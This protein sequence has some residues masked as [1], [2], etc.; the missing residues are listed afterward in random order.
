MSKN[1]NKTSKKEKSSVLVENTSLYRNSLIITQDVN[2]IVSKMP[3]DYK[4]VCG[5]HLISLNQN[6]STKIFQAYSERDNVLKLRSIK[7]LVLAINSFRI[8]LISLHK[9][10][11][12]PRFLFTS[13]EPISITMIRQS[14]GW[15]K[16]TKEKIDNG[17]LESKVS[18]LS[19]EVDE[20]DKKPG[21]KE[22]EIIKSVESEVTISSVEPV[23]FNKQ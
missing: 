18:E 12:V 1:S 2:R 23:D 13:V 15:L 16:S 21:S 7:E 17:E 10:G 20:K 8:Y 9:N 19:E 5:S 22:G 14:K 11:V 3:K 6:I 4:Y